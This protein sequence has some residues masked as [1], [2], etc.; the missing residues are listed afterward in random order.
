MEKHYGTVQVG[1]VPSLP[2]R[3]LIDRPMPR[4]CEVLVFMSN[5]AVRLY[6]VGKN[7]SLSIVSWDRSDSFF[8]R[9]AAGRGVVY[10][11]GHVAFAYLVYVGY[12]ISAERVL[13]YR[14]ELVPLV[15]GSQIPDVIDKPLAFYG[16]LESGRSFGH[17]LGGMFLLVA[18]VAW[19]S[20]IVGNHYTQ[21]DWRRQLFMQAPG[22]VLIGYG[23]H[24]LGDFAGAI[25]T[26]DP[27]SARFLLWPLFVMPRLPKDD[28][29]P[30][31]RLIQIYQTPTAHPQL[32]LIIVALCVF[33]ALRVYPRL[34]RT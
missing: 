19:V 23:S 13:P 15:I 12:G 9:P 21:D 16:V 26:G 31:I 25:V 4:V 8:I 22:A 29:A 3:D 28:T 10:P 34:R 6:S 14:W 30:W 11:L 20:T 33:L 18:G 5:P 7:P 24:L 27:W 1:A 17:S 32:E 2:A